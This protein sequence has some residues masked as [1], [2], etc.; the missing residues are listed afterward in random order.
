MHGEDRKGVIIATGAQGRLG[1]LI[2]GLLKSQRTVI[3]TAR[4][5]PADLIL[6]G[7]GP[8]PALPRCHAVLALW[9]GTSN[10]PAKAREN[11]ALAHRSR[12]VAEAS[13]AR[14][15]IHLSSAAVYGPGL[16][17]R[18]TDALHP[19]GGYGRAKA[20]MEREIAGFDSDQARHVCLRLANVVGADSLAPALLGEGPVRLDRFP[21]GRGPLRS[22]IAPG[23]L[24]RIVLALTDLAPETLP[25]VINVAAPLPVS[26]AALARAAGHDITWVPAPQ[27]AVQEVG[28]N[29][30]RL[31]AL[32]PAQHLHRTAPDMIADWRHLRSGG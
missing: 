9:G 27:T 23:D 16:D 26:M 21:D 14:L 15:V 6:Q 20:Q 8:L 3:A 7:D 29:T 1:R 19:L 24:A 31:Q 5:P 25:A 10:D 28:L 2:C 30:E 4:R 11:I 13:G 18:E 17:L 32:L 22:Y 12:A